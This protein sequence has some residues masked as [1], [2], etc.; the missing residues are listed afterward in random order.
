MSER[1]HAV[2]R[3]DASPA[4]GGGHV[5]RCLAL[6]ESMSRDG[7]SVT[8]AGTA[9]TPA[10]VPALARSPH[11]WIE[12]ENP[13]DAAVLQ[14]AVPAGCDMLVIDHY[15]LDAAY[16]SAC[17]S[18]ARRILAIDDLADR[19]HDCD[20]LIDPIPGRA[21]SS[22][23]ARVTQGTQIASGP[24]YALLR[25]AFAVMRAQR[26]ARDGDVRR[27]LLSLGTAD[28]SNQL[29]A[30]I[31]ALAGLNVPLD[32]AVGSAA[33]D[34]AAI[35]EAAHVAGA[36]LHID[37]TNM[38]EL[39]RDA[40]IAVF[41][42]GGT[43]WEAACLGLPMI[44]MITADNQRAVAEAMAARSAAV[45]AATPREA[46]A[47]AHALLQDTQLRDDL[48]RAAASLCD[49]LGAQ[50]A[51]LLA[52]PERDAAG[53]SVTLRPASFEDADLI[54]RWQQAP[55]T[56]RFARNPT[57]PTADD[58]R[59]WMARTLQSQQSLVHLVVRD[60]T[61][62]GLLRLDRTEKGEYEISIL[63]DPAAYRQGIGLA[64]LKLARRFL[65]DARLLAQVLPGNESSRLLFEKAGFH[66][67]GGGWF[68]HDDL[69][70]K[71]SA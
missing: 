12:L 1:R 35:R 6:A 30:L 67:L 60:D 42:A 45:V 19:R 2:I 18:W 22:Y 59:A 50:R 69:R 15:G 13:G 46:A 38:A 21:V 16:E 71:A 4:I 47:Q 68:V 34:L 43:T 25:P 31:E 17:R 7:W 10:V 40:D 57:V 8:F 32:V 26:G 52:Y 70:M 5:A 55:E 65:L 63:T 49:G 23:A 9:D 33:R 51:T 37:A 48:S 58:H 11:G 3:A 27:V 29:A 64:A 56:R 41:A 62:V 39:M 61:P 14:T 53:H 20:I 44:L 36:C 66:A 54:L 28:S 24:A